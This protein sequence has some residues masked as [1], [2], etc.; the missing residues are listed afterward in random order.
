MTKAKKSTKSSPISLEDIITADTK[1]VKYNVNFERLEKNLK[2]NGADNQ[3]FQKIAK[4]LIDYHSQ[5]KLDASKYKFQ[6]DAFEILRHHMGGQK[7]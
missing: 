4:K 7:L 6:A 1:H 5:K 2:S 3:H